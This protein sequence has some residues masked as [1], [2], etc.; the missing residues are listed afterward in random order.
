MIISLIFFKAT[1]DCFPCVLIVLILFC[2]TR[3]VSCVAISPWLSFGTYR[4]VIFVW[5]LISWTLFARK[6]CILFVVISHSNTHCESVRR[7]VSPITS[8]S[9]FFNKLETSHSNE[10]YHHFITLNK[11]QLWFWGNQITLWALPLE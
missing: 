4:N 7:N 6:T 8:S 5:L 11:G 10:T 9:S 3:T 1:I 2:Q